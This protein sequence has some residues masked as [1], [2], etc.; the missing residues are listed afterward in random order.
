[1]TTQ[2]QSLRKPLQITTHQRGAPESNAGDDFHFLWASRQAI[3]LVSPSTSLSRLVIEGVSPS[4]TSIK[5]AT[6][7]LLLGVDVTEYHG[8]DDFESAKR[9]VVSQLKYSTRHPTTSW[10]V[11]RLCAKNK[12]QASVIQRL[13]DVYRHFVHESSKNEVLDKLSISLVSN[14]HLALNLKNALKHARD[15]LHGLASQNPAAFSKLF[16][17][18]NSQDANLVRQL[19]QASGLTNADF[20]LFLNILRL[21]STGGE[22]RE[23]QRIRLVQELAQFVSYD[24]LASLR[25]LYELIQ[26]EAM[27]EKGG[28]F[29]LT[30]H[31][32]LA[33]LGV[34]N[35]YS[36]FPAPSQ[37]AEAT[38][39]IKTQNARDVAAHIN[40]AASGR[41]LIHGTTGIGK[42]TTIQM[43]PESLPAGSVAIVYDCFAQ[44]S[45]LDP[46]S[47]RHSQRRALLELTNELAVRTGTPF[48]IKPPEDISDLQREFRIRL[49]AAAKVISKTPEALLVLIID[50]AD[51]AV[52]AGNILHELSFVPDL[53]KIPLPPGCRVVMSARSHRRSILEPPTDTVEVELRGFTPT[54]SALHLRR[55]FPT[56]DD[57]AC[58]AF[59]TRTGGNPR[60]QSYVLHRQAEPGSE[61]TL[62]SV[63]EK[64]K[65]TPD[66]I[67]LDLYQAAVQH[68]IQTDQA[69]RYLALLISLTRPV[70]LTIFA[71]SSGT[72]IEE[73]QNF[74]KAL[75]PGLLLEGETVAFRDEDF[76]T[77]L[78]EKVSAE[79]F[80]RAHATLGK[81]F[82][83]TAQANAYAASSVVEHLFSAGQFEDVILLAING[84]APTVVA[85]EMQQLQIR[86]RRIE[87]GL[88]AATTL[89]RRGD[90]LRLIMLAGE[91]SRTDGALTALIRRNPE[92]AALFGDVSTVSRIYLQEENRT[93]LGPAQLRTAALFARLPSGR[94]RAISHFRDAE[95]WLRRRHV[96]P[97]NERYS[98]QIDAQDIASAAE[99]VF[100]ARGFPAAYGWLRHWQPVGVVLSALRLLIPSLS[101]QVKVSKL[102]TQ[103]EKTRMPVW[104]MGAILASLWEVGI[105]PS[106]RLVDETA[107]HLDNMAKRRR[108]LKGLT[109][110]WIPSFSELLTA[111]KLNKD[112][113]LRIAS[114]LAPEFPVTEPSTHEDLGRFDGP[115]RV[116]CIEAALTGRD[117]TIDDLMPKPVRQKR[118]KE[119][120]QSSPN[121]YRYQE[122]FGNVLPTYQLRARAI[123]SPLKLEQIEQEV[124]AT[125]KAQQGPTEHRWFEYS[126]HYSLWAIRVVETLLLTKGDAT[127]LIERIADLGERAVRGSAPKL[128]LDLAQL[129]ASKA[130]YRQFAY[131]LIE[132]AARYVMDNPLSRTERWQLLLDCAAL[133]SRYD[134]SLSQDYYARAL[135]AAEGIDDDSSLLLSLHARMAQHMVGNVDEETARGLSVRLSRLVEAH[136]EFVT[137]TSDLPWKATLAVICALDPASGFALATRWDDE[138]HLSI[139]SGIVPLALE[140]LKHNF[141]RPLEVLSLL[142]LT[143]EYYNIAE[144]AISVLEKLR[145]SGPTARQDLLK[146]L[147]IVSTWMRRDVPIDRRKAAARTIIEWAENHGFASL[148]G[149][150]ELQILVE[151]TAPWLAQEERHSETTYWRDPTDATVVHKIIE[152]AKKGSLDNFETHLETIAR[153]SYFN[154]KHIKAYLQTLGDAMSSANRLPFLKQLVMTD[155]N[156]LIGEYLIDVLAHFLTAWQGMQAVRDWTPQ[157]V[158][159]YLERHLPALL[160][161]E[162]N[163]EDKLAKVFS[164]PNLP[165]E[166]RFD[167]LVPAVSK[168]VWELGPRSIYLTAAFLS[169][170][171]VP[172]DLQ[173]VFEWSLSSTEDKVVKDGGHLPKIPEIDLSNDPPKVIAH[174]LWSLFGHPDKEVRWRALHTGRAL[175]GMPNDAL[176]DDLLRLSFTEA[177]GA[178]RSPQLEFY[179]MSAR[180]WLLLLMLRHANDHPETL[181][182]YTGA[183]VDHALSPHFPHAQIREVAKRAA[184]KLAQRLPGVISHDTVR[185]LAYTNT[186]HSCLYP[187]DRRTKPHE[188]SPTAANR[189]ARSQRFEFDILDTIPY[190]YEPLAE[191]FGNPTPGVTDRADIWVSD[192]W[193]RTKADWWKDPRELGKRDRSMLMHASHGSV[194]R[195]EGL[196]VYIE[197]HAM[198]CVAGEMIDALP[199]S[200][201][202]YDEEDSWNEWLSRHVGANPSYWLADLRSPT[203]YHPEF[204]GKFPPIDEWLRRDNPLEFE[205]ALGLDEVRRE[206]A[207]V[208]S[209]HIEV[210][211]SERRG[212][213]YIASALANPKHYQSLLH[214]LQNTP[215]NDYT[216]PK[217]SWGVDDT[218]SKSPGFEL[219]P[220][221]QHVS[222]PE[223]LDKFDPLARLGSS[224]VD[225]LNDNF[226]DTMAV[227]PT[228]NLLQFHQKDGKVVAENEIWNDNLEESS[229]RI[230]QPFSTGQRLWVNIAT[231]LE[232]LRRRNRCLVIKVEFSRNRS[233]HYRKPGEEYDLG[234]AIVYIVHQNGRLE[235]VDGYREIGGAN[236]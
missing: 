215:A 84:P 159:L 155:P 17:E 226:L 22:S 112:R 219:E 57:A 232:Y 199:V 164:L 64:A 206:G 193:A 201:S 89:G 110:E 209:A 28:S 62:A 185:E 151:T 141:L 95:A 13:A 167:L 120:S 140:T 12:K 2:K 178:F 49:D 18:L 109:E 105:A 127:P 161:Y 135:A 210:G 35:S 59:H 224:H 125:V 101:Y 207:L 103:V 211:D 10:S 61:V 148:T 198:F 184:L 48:L 60:V 196:R 172:P 150:P 160:A 180:V 21:D 67:F 56:A 75:D 225:R 156:R 190:W 128:W 139:Q 235:T 176:I 202:T 45:Y 31:D 171:L 124:D 100:W 173:Q 92:L 134:L 81:Y 143:G 94:D 115:L 50:A 182:K 229:E 25:K 138:E 174:F 163:A 77:F 41:I 227:T 63:L 6:G 102:I 166:G 208:T 223:G 158:Q 186:V 36:L 76:E 121:R 47:Q 131:R 228:A 16:K 66:E 111:H 90:A 216:L 144:E 132:R 137:E 187:R 123:Q 106:K 154:G 142:H 96:L 78:R 19:K 42:T 15:I 98:W 175:L 5:P 70:P 130:T 183:F 221:L 165:R 234:K 200:I 85:D 4:D 145:A 74:C 188:P 39:L 30:S 168:H 214:A 97:E 53:W 73:A 181:T 37:L 153:T 54:E 26:Q 82:L 217:E 52:I 194:P 129:L 191:V 79:D 152:D 213:V 8:G 1:M 69:Q 40:D 116:K 68:W 126:R 133:T 14:Q 29:G 23:F 34:S 218:S 231:L 80:W 43:V 44:G 71:D 204:W 55:S 51:N 86:K 83:Q 179:W 20:L 169:E 108:H 122:A 58:Q 146:A 147:G 197:Y 99:A 65:E 230:T 118:V 192:R 24:P 9:V 177:A 203:P 233:Y 114:A 27:P 107:T 157:G 195:Y 222:L 136:E 113:T 149:V 87:L 7:D 11:S 189:K 162:Y 205:Q 117:L 3:Q 170:G 220:W 236:P 119:K 91:Q 32:V 88:Q 104:A 33:C 212:T 93:W 72:N 38:D 46:G